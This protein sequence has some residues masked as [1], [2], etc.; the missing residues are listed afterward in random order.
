[1][2][3]FTACRF[4]GLTVNEFFNLAASG[5]TEFSLRS[6]LRKL[7]SGAYFATIVSL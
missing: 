6:P 5:L 3:V 7:G 1:V 4:V 2:V